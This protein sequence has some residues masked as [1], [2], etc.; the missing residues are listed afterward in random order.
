[1]IIHDKVYNL[2]DFVER[3]PGGLISVMKVI[4]LLFLV[5]NLTVIKGVGGDG[6]ALFEGKSR[7]CVVLINVCL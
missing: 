3:H 4:Y 2:T 7:C 1:M 5:S 6:T